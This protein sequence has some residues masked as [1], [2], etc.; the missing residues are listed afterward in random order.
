MNTSKLF[1]CTALAASAALGQAVILT[2]GAW[3]ALPG[4][5]GLPGTVLEDDMVPFS[6]LGVEAG[7]VQ[8]RVVRK[9]DNTLLFAWRVIRNDLTSV[10]PVRAFRLGGFEV[11]TYDTDWSTT[12]VGTKPAN[13]AFLFDQPGGHVA[14]QFSA[15]IGGQ[16]GIMAMESSRFFWLDTDATAYAR[17]AQYDLVI[18]NDTTIVQSTFAPVPE[19]AS[20]AALGLGALALFRRRK[21]QA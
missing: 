11:P 20:L 8:N 13:H 21:R 9:A 5:P 18:G 1:L 4:T 15:N 16:D 19:P 3:S 17:T 12:S 10:Q 14:W 7:T 6:I 2:P